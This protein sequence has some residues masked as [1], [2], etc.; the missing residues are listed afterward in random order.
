[1]NFRDRLQVI[2]TSVGIVGAINTVQNAG[3]VRAVG[4]E[5]AVDVRLRGALDEPRLQ[6]KS[7]A[8]LQHFDERGICWRDSAMRAQGLQTMFPQRNG[9]T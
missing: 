8:T 2:P 3:W 1:M 7:R 6:G 9:R 4:V 5:A